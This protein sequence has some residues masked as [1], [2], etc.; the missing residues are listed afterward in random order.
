MNYQQHQPPD[1]LKPYVRYF[2]VL[3]SEAVGDSARTFRPITD[4]CP[5]LFFQP[6]EAGTFH[7]QDQKQLPAFFLYGQTIRHRELRT[8]G[9]F[10][11]M[12]VCFYPHA[13]H[14]V[15]GLDADQLTDTCI[16]IGSMTPKAGSCLTDQLSEAV[17]TPH[18]IDRL[19]AYLS[20]QI[21]IN[22]VKPDAVTEYALSRLLA[23]QGSVSLNELRETANVSERSFERRFKQRV[24]IS[25]K[26]FARICRF[27]AS[28][29]QLR[30]TDYD[31]L[32]DIAFENGYAD[33]SHFIRAFNEFA[34]FSP[35]HYRNQSAGIAHNLAEWP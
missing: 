22:G 21:R 23:S 15:F 28:L 29:S 16:A 19:S 33:Q 3:E 12:G 10:N 18:K 25:P 13:L 8:S 32:S 4:G 30:T 7:D 31:K 6:P 9:R 17:S 20:A 26:L 35:R 5:G 2:W 34:G 24:G 14:S 1:H 11:A 27:Q